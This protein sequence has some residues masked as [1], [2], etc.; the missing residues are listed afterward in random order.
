VLALD[1]D[2]HAASRDLR[3]LVQ[4]LAGTVSG[5]GDALTQTR[6]H[7]DCHGLNAR[8][9]ID[10]PKA[11]QAI[12]FDFDDSGFGYLAYDLAVHLWAQLSFG[13]T[14][15]PMWHAF[16]E[17]YRSVRPL[18]RADEAALPAFVAIRHI[19]LMGEYA[20]RVA[21]WGDEM[22]SASHLSAA[23]SANAAAGLPA[24]DVSATQGKMLALFV[25]MTNASRPHLHRR[26][27]AKQ[28]ALP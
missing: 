25:R 20:G 21:E 15:Y 10:G 23:L 7:G 13:R 1:V 12:L 27:Q 17:G 22:L 28:P 4:R 5:M 2:A 11:G 8:I 3:A 19:W 18:R 26:R 14:R 16:G 24:I 9:A 6:C